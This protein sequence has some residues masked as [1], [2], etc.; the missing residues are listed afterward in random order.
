MPGGSWILRRQ[1]LAEPHFH[2]GE[3]LI[4]KVSPAFVS[5][6]G[7]DSGRFSERIP[8]AAGMGRCAEVPVYLP[9]P[10]DSP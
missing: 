9:A 7:F 2:F 10:Q 4:P 3:G 8:G 1:E 6:F 5:L